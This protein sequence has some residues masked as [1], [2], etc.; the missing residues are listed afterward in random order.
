M[1]SRDVTHVTRAN[2]GP[3]VTWEAILRRCFNCTRFL[4]LIAVSICLLINHIF[5]KRFTPWETFYLFHSC[6]WSGDT[7]DTSRV[8][9]LDPLQSIY[10][11]MRLFI[12]SIDMRVL[13]ALSCL[14]KARFLVE[15]LLTRTLAISFT[16][17]WQFILSFV[18]VHWLIYTIS[19]MR[20]YTERHCRNSAR[21][22]HLFMHYLCYPSWKGV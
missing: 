13:W 14:V 17:T 7:S 4:N 22:L 20:S 6:M 5:F 16:E 8:W 9:S 11:S 3:E 15:V 19:T 2:H 10:L 12:H 18:L 1:K 21:S